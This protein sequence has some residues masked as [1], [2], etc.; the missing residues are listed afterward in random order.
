MR[1]N[2]RMR[3][4]MTRAG[5]RQPREALLRDEYP[6]G[7]FTGDSRSC[8]PWCAR[9]A[10]V[11]F[12]GLHLDQYGFPKDNAFGPAPQPWRY[13][14]SEDFPPFI[15]DARKAAR[16]AQRDS[17]VIFNAVGNWPIEAVAP[18]SQDAV[19]IEVWPPYDHYCDLQALILGARHLAPT[20]Q[21]ILAAYLKPLQD[22]AEHHLPRAEAA[23]LLASAAIW[24][25]GGFHLLLGESD[26][27]LCDAY[28]PRYTTLRPGFAQVMRAYYDFVVRYENVLCDPR[29]VTE[30]HPAH[31]EEVRVRGTDTSASGQAGTIWAIARHMPG[32]LT[33][34]LINL[35]AAYTA[36][37]NGLQ[38]EQPVLRDLAVEIPV[39]SAHAIGTVFAA[40]PDWGSGRPEQLPF[41]SAGEATSHLV[42]ARLPSLQ[43]WAL[44]VVRLVGA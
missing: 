23:T 26:G 24:A 41:A 10:D 31:Q 20:K 16:G 40:S 9:W 5:S 14:L 30:P 21:V 38:P 32:V 7:S 43:Y 19:Y 4:S 2:I 44:I 37:W 3:C 25:N 13:D 27:A 8:R 6:S 18:T 39:T 22:T 42:T 28:Y 1:C 11:P 34:S 17:R 35:T 29:L 12:D 36:C 33:V 15:D